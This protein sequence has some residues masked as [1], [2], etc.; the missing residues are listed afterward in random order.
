MTT[1]RSLLLAI[2]TIGC[3]AASA[4]SAQ[5]CTKTWSSATSGSWGNAKLWT[6]SGVPSST[7]D[8]CI[9]A[10]G[11]YTVTLPPNG[12]VA[13]TLTA[14]GGPGEV[15]IDVAGESYDNAGN[16]SNETDLSV[17]E[18]AT[19]AANTKLILE[20]T[21]ATTEA[22]VEPHGAGAGLVGGSVVEAGQIEALNTGAPWANRIKLANL[23]IEPGASLLDASGT[24]LFLKEGEGAY[25]W[26]T[27]NEGTVTVDSGA[28]LEM[29]PSFAGKADFINDASVVNSGSITGHGAEWTQGGGSV[30]GNPVVLQSASTLID[31]AGTGS[32]LGNYGSLTVTGTI[33]AGQTVTVRGEPFNYGGETYSST[34]LNGAGKELI[35]DGTLVLNPTGS[36]EAGGS[37]NVEGGSIHNN[38]VIDVETE[39]A[40]RITQLLEGLTNGPSGQLDLNGGIFQGNNGAPLSNEGLVTIAPG[41]VYQLQEAASF[42]NE[43]GG[44]L[45]PKIASASSFGAIQLTSPCCNG[46]GVFKAGGTLTPVL[47]GGFVPAIGQEFDLFALNGGK[48]EGAFAAVGGG[49]SADYS[50]ETSESAYVGVIYHASGSST[51]TTTA[52]SGS[53][54]PPPLAHLQ[55]PV[56]GGHGEFTVTLSCPPAGAACATATL[57]A[58]VTEH[59]KGGKI[60]AITARKRKLKTSARTRQVLIASAGVSLAAGTTRTLTVALNAAGRALL[61]RYGKLTTKVTIE[62]GASTLESTILT[63]QRPKPPKRK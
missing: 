48:F 18:S 37:V 55:K 30:T 16:P 57:T 58:T 22:K 4:A 60:T 51:T 40:S 7:D 35:N 50:H 26:S 25:P 23:Q 19:L 27:T 12:G 45:S 53:K 1:P 15:T 24:L 47:L 6:P 59:L 28:S 3:L 54:P 62:S 42:A 29:Q 34:A 5:A 38:G 20:A 10:S 9:T 11:T 21:D 44:T 13:K 31:S 46:P 41:A 61:D 39:T 56:K 14:G 36:G 52:G 33:P 49:F 63:L 17:V 2:L 8:V 43:A 32:F